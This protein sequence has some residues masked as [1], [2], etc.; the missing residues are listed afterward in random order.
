MRSGEGG[1]HIMKVLDR[2]LDACAIAA[3]G[4]AHNSRNLWLIKLG[5]PDPC[6]RAVAEIALQGKKPTSKW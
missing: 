6:Y 1:L 2:G 4:S 5:L 3:A